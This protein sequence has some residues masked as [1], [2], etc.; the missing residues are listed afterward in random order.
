MHEIRIKRLQMRVI[1]EA[2]KDVF[3]HFDELIG[4][5]MRKI[6]TTDQFLSPGFGG[7]VKRACRDGGWRRLESRDGRVQTVEIGV[8]FVINR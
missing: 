3:P 8:E 5:A 6:Q 7:R 2:G 4:A 1:R